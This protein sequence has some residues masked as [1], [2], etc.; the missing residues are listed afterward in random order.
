MIRKERARVRER[1]KEKAIGHAQVATP[2][3]LLAAMPASNADLNTE[4][5]DSLIETARASAY[6]KEALVELIMDEWRKKKEREKLFEGMEEHQKSLE[7]KE[8]DELAEIASA[9]LIAEDKASLIET[10]RAG[11]PKQP[12]GE[13]LQEDS[14]TNKQAE[15]P[16]GALITLIMDEWRAK[17]VREGEEGPEIRFKSLAEAMAAAGD[18]EKKEEKKEKKKEKKRKKEEEWETWG[19]EKWSADGAWDAEASKKAKKD[20]KAKKEVEWC[21]DEAWAEEDAPAAKKKSKKEKAAPVDTNDDDLVAEIIWDNKEDEVAPA[22]PP[23]APK[24]KKKKKKGDE[25]WW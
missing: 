23:D 3:A 1:R 19:T 20:K 9:E 16:K 13:T 7:E 5:K 11:V 22:T 2:I 6:P 12:E 15:N 21:D 17:K 4:D 24:K 25:E 14:E 8:L 10:A 18:S